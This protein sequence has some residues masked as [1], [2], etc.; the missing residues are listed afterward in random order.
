MQRFKISG[1]PVVDENNLLVGILPTVIYVLKLASIFPVSEV[2]TKQPLV[3]VPVGT[4]LNE[5]KVKL[6]KHRIEKLLVVDDGG[7][8][9]GLI[10]VKDIQKAIRYPFAAKTNSDDFASRQLSAQRAITGTRR[11]N[12]SNLAPTPSLSTPRTDIVSRVI[13]AVKKVKQNF[14]D[15]RYIAGNVAYRRSNKST[16]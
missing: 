5:A 1:I 13:E 4:T 14:P 3:T 9:K 7:L 12:L 15:L 2:M 11:R 8:L 10:T 16:D 6:Q